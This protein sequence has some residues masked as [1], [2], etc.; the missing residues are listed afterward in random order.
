MNKNPEIID[1]KDEH[2]PDFLKGL[3]NRMIM[4]ASFIVGIAILSDL[5][6][7]CN[8]VRDAVSECVN[9]NMDKVC[10]E[11]YYEGLNNVYNCVNSMGGEFSRPD[12][13]KEYNNEIEEVCK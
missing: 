1:S 2:A 9:N 12:V 11:N 10:G 5:E 3:R 6:F 4:L 8:G 7:T 13:W